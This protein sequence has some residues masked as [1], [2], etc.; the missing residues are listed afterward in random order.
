MACG[1]ADRTAEGPRRPCDR[2]LTG[3][4]QRALGVLWSWRLGCE[5]RKKR[6]PRGPLRVRDA[7]CGR[8]AKAVTDRSCCPT[9]DFRWPAM[10]HRRT[11]GL[12]PVPHR[13][14]SSLRSMATMDAVERPKALED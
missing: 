10:G 12:P 2:R 3:A 1:G 7:Q 13:R 6:V 11:R 14:G 5:G 8:Q 9:D 4:V